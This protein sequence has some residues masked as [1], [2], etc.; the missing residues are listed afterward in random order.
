MART[1]KTMVVVH[2][3]GLAQDRKF[4]SY[5]AVA[6]TLHEGEE[7]T[8]RVDL[9]IPFDKGSQFEGETFNACEGYRQVGKD[10]DGYWHSRF[11]APE[12]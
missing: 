1:K 5:A 12:Y 6:R 10:S 3:K 2:P 8:V 4:K 7:V 9:E 11:P